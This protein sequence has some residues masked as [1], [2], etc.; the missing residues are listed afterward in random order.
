MYERWRRLGDQA[1]LDEISAY[2]ELDCRSTR[3]C[4][5]WLLGLRPAEATWRHV[6]EAVAPTP[7]KVVQ[8]QEAEERT[9]ALIA[10]LMAGGSETDCSWRELLCHLLEFRREA[11]P[12]WWSMFARREMTP[13]ELLDDA[14][15][16]AEIA[17]DPGR[18]SR[19][20]KNS[21][22]YAFTFPGQDFKLRVG[23]EVLRAS[24][25]EAAG[26]VMLIDEESRRLKVKLGPSRTR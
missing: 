1:L 24:T 19:P 12:E 25:G 26:T 13:Q 11:K 4:R 17:A 7:E 5:D 22:I 20:D 16:L 3:L 14:A 6:G 15:Y 8:R 9:A 10:A 18:A 23:D 2:N 21:T